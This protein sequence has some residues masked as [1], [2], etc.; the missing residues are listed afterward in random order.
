LWEFPGGKVLDGESRLQ[1]AARELDEE[2]G[3]EE[4]SLG[5]AL[6]SVEDA[7][8]PFVIEFYETAAKGTP[9]ARE[10]TEIG[11][12]TADELV[13]MDLAPADAWFAR[14]LSAAAS[15]SRSH[16]R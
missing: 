3:L 8:S 14:T 10:H 5:T 13:R 9:E 1:A 4:V 11:W 2:L 12:F 6:L 7:G 16:R 15:I